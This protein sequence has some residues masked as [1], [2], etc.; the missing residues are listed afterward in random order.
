MKKT[1]RKCQ[2]FWNQEL[3]NL[4]FS[5]CQAETQYLNFKVYSNK[6]LTLKNKLKSNFKTNQQMF[7]KRFRYYKRQFA[8]SNQALL[9]KLAMEKSPNVWDQIKK[10]NCPPKRPP[11]EV[12]KEDGSITRDTREVSDKWYRDIS[13][14]FAGIKENPDMAF[15]KSFYEE[16]V[17]IKEQFEKMS[18]DEQESFGCVTGSDHLNGQLEVNEVSEAIDQA[19]LRKAFLEIPNE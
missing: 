10:L 19:Q 12:L 7:D 4:W 16:I 9:H 2:P 1:F 5:S 11:L 18:E 15:D 17:R 14:L 6:D 3:A 8:K 13:R